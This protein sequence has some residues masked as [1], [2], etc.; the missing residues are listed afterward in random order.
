M[1]D[2][3]TL[4]YNLCMYCTIKLIGKAVILKHT[5][6]KM[7]VTSKVEIFNIYTFT[8]ILQNSSSGTVI[9]TVYKHVCKQCLRAYARKNTLDHL[10]VCHNTLHKL[11]YI[12][13]TVAYSN[14]SGEQQVK[15]HLDTKF[16]VLWRM[17]N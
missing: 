14:P 4:G 13:C 3:Q 6:P 1:N 2:S 16:S 10:N 15:F 11:K 12:Y 7:T 5:I 9:N 8:S 17:Q